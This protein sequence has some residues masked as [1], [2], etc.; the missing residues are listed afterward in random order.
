MA[1]N[2]DDI[3]YLPDPCWKLTVAD[4]LAK[5]EQKWPGTDPATVKIRA[6]LWQGSGPH[7]EA[8]AELCLERVPP[9]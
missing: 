2:A 4:I 1:K 3:C 7:P 6:A 8:E 9:Q 5:I